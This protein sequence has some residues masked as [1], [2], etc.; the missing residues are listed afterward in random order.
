[1]LTPFSLFSGYSALNYL[2]FLDYFPYS[3]NISKSLS[4]PPCPPPPSVTT[5]ITQGVLSP[6]GPKS[7]ENFL[8]FFL[9][10][11][12]AYTHTHTF[13]YTSI[14]NSLCLFSM[15]PIFSLRILIFF[16]FSSI[17]ISLAFF[18]LTDSGFFST[19]SVPHHFVLKSY[20]HVFNFQ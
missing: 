11:V 18:S 1:M 20:N 14:L 3:W 7:T 9:S 6:W 13:V 5:P 12:D 15:F 8:P 19:E 16:L 17:R 2:D 10:S 4:L